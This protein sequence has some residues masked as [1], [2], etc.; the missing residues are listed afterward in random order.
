MRIAIALSGGVDSA[1]AAFRLKNQS[2][3]LVGITIKTW[4]NARQDNVCS[5]E[6]DKLETKTCGLADTLKYASSS[7]KQLGI[8]HDIIDLSKQFAEEIEK[9]FINEYVNGR[10]PNP[11]VYCNS[12]IKFGYLL[13]EVRKKG[14]SRIATGHY[15]RIIQKDGN[16][17]LAE[18]K[19]KRYDQSYFLFNIS[20][21]ELSVI[22]FPIGEM[23]KKEVYETAVKHNFISAERKS[24]QDICFA[25]N[26]GGYK[27]YLD[28]NKIKK[29]FL[30]GEI[31]DTSGKVVGEHKGIALYTIG[32]RRG[33]GLAR[34]NPIY[35]L[36]INP[37]KNTIVV[38]EKNFAMKKRI[39]VS[40]I[41]WLISKSFDKNSEFLVRIRY[42]GKKEKAVLEPYGNN[43]CIVTFNEKQFAPAPGQAAVFYDGEIVAGGGWIEEVME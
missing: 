6:Q 1:V 22:E 11:C 26:D 32:Q 29:A 37:K 43:E 39:R 38:G 27:E 10:T 3:D 41:N 21:K 33:I 4:I 9:Y 24:S 35:V 15:A 13:D 18:A 7:A 30:P 25:G 36:E 19:D 12:R 16:F 23:T 40:R 42:N 20:K 34:E 14:L 2:Q 5:I 31:I 17:Y 28:R 8:P